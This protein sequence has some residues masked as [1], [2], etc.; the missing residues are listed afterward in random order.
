MEL[1]IVN[2]SGAR[3]PKKFLTEWV[4]NLNRLGA[5][6]VSPKRY[7][8]KELTI[9]FLSQNE[10]RKLNKSYRGK[11]YATD[12]LSFSSDD[13][14]S[15]GE[16]VICPEVIARQA[17]QHGLLIREELGYMVIHGFLHLLGYDHERSRREEQRM[18]LIQDR[19]F[20]QLL[21]RSSRTAK[22]KLKSQL[23]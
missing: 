14:A 12:V 3:V 20:E 22:S 11:D 13:P 15:L 18:F 7:R 21:S 1:M 10:A 8:G 4:R 9:A 2:S 17:R 19:L 5:R 6:F 23:R 16:L